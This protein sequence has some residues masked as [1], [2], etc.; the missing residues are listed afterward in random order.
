M[1]IASHHISPEENHRWKGPYNS[2]SEHLP[3]AGIQVAPK[4]TASIYVKIIPCVPFLEPPN[5]EHGITWVI[6]L[7]HVP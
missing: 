1:D 4:Q 6:F 3:I 5:I 7:G 2:L